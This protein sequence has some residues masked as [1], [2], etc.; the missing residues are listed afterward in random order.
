MKTYEQTPWC[1]LEL[2]WTRTKKVTPSLIILA[3]ILAIL[4][5]PAI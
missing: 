1:S 4:A 5:P 2:R 3:I